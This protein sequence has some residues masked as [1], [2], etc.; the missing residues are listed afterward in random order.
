MP[1]E[2]GARRAESPVQ[3]ERH[4]VQQ[5][6]HSAGVPLCSRLMRVCVGVF[7]FLWLTDGQQYYEGYI[8]IMRGQRSDF[9]PRFPALAGC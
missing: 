5:P 8:E 7:V 3:F 6:L 1:R 2:L 9:S 4:T